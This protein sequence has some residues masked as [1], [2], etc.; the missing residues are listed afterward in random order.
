[1]TTET[2]P[3]GPTQPGLPPEQ[4]QAAA[5]EALLSGLVATPDEEGASLAG[6]TA[7]IKEATA[8]GREVVDA[9]RL[10]TLEEGFDRGLATDINSLLANYD[11]LYY[12]SEWEL[13]GQLKNIGNVKTVLER[14][15]K[16]FENKVESSP[17][18]DALRRMHKKILW[19]EGLETV[20]AGG[21]ISTATYYAG[22]ERIKNIPKIKITGEHNQKA[23]YETL[24]GIEDEEIKGDE[25]SRELIIQMQDTAMDAS[26]L[27]AAGMHQREVERVVSPTPATKPRERE[28]M[29]VDE[30]TAK[31]M[32]EVFAMR[33]PSETEGERMGGIIRVDWIDPK[34]GNAYKGVA[35]DFINYFCLM[36][37]TEAGRRWYIN[38]MTSFVYS[39]A[40]NR[41]EKGEDAKAIAEEVRKEAKRLQDNE[42]APD[43]FKDTKELYANI[44]TRSMIAKHLGDMTAGELGVGWT[45]EV[46]A[47]E[48]LEDVE[49]EMFKLCKV[50]YDQLSEDQ[51]KK[52]AD[53]VREETEAGKEWPT[54]SGY[55]V[56]RVS[57]IGS[58]YNADDVPSPFFPE[59]YVEDYQARAE[60]AAEVHKGLADSFRRITRYY[61]PDW[62]PP[63]DKYCANNPFVLQRV[64]WLVNDRYANQPERRKGKVYG[65]TDYR[66]LNYMRKYARAWP[67]WVTVPVK[68][69]KGNIVKNPDGSDKRVPY[70]VPYFY[71]PAWYS[72][73]F[74]RSL[75]DGGKKAVDVPSLHE[76]F[77]ERRKLSK[78]DFRKYSDQAVDWANVNRAQL[79]RGLVIL[80][81]S[82]K[83]SSDGSNQ[84]G[85]FVARPLDI[86]TLKDWDKRMARLGVRGEDIVAGVTGMLTFVPIAIKL[87]AEKTGIGRLGD[88]K[89]VSNVAERQRIEKA[90]RDAIAE[91]K[92]NAAYLPKSKGLS[93]TAIQNFN[94]TYTKI[95]DTY[96]K[97]E[98]DW[99]IKAVNQTESDLLDEAVQFQQDM[100]DILRMNGLTSSL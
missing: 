54:V 25:I 81:L 89:L 24:E 68:D 42:Y 3:P 74:W 34:T 6:V 32:E 45:Y 15:I 66:I 93:K 99:Q 65:K 20:L 59:R 84:F 22:E 80:Y 12:P 92:L 97:I 19:A 38:L 4:A 55:V 50:P 96:A 40:I 77:L 16:T 69:A 30:K 100:A 72:L 13:E 83:F 79:A 18:L 1:M 17:T 57:E 95:I 76:R 75:G 73:N 60:S 86:N 10:A 21:M 51:R 56:L 58:I 63:I 64:D 70:A 29:Y 78:V 48:E 62:R 82:H 5:F 31:L 98:M 91:L 46:T 49:K 2:P 67:T 41:L 8:R 71:P 35:K 87:I 14:R 26:Y 11:N 43:M 61:L 85:N 90:Y 7:A 88:S 53:R 23:Y 33:D 47:W 37:N 94:M 28:K 27:V 52:F 39:D 36:E 9:E 44:V